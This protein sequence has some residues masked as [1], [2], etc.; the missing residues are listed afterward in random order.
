M[1]AATR[2]VPIVFTIVPDPVGAGFVD[3][4]ARPGGNATGFSQFE[5]GISGKWLELL[6]EIA[7]ATTR[8]AVLREPTF[9]AAV[10]QLAALQA[11]AP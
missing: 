7:P 4:L 5:Y 6:K 3:S 8:V 9:T 1:L 10:A 11:V 2:T